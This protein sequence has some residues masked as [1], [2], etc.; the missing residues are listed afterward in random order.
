MCKVIGYVVS[1]R[2]KLT[3]RLGYSKELYVRSE[4][5][6]WTSF[7]KKKSAAMPAL[8][9]QLFISLNNGSN[10][11]TWHVGMWRVCSLPW[12]STSL[13]TMW[14]ETAVAK[15]YY[16]QWVKSCLLSIQNFQGVGGAQVEKSWN[17]RGSGEYRDASKNG[18]SWGVG[19]Q[20]G[21]NPPWR[22]YGYLLEPHNKVR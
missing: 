21:K 14:L 19:G 5:L 4:I 17:S 16:N 20:T 6:V 15:F 9:I 8:P 12:K 3:L 7:V 13:S 18:K 1:A 2:H 22:G 10:I 11:S